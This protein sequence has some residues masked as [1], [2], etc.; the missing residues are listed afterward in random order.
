MSRLAT[1]V[2]LF[3]ALLL[4]LAQVAQMPPWEGF[5]EPGHYSYIEQIAE[6]GTWPR[7]GDP[8]SADVD[9]YLKVAPTASSLRAPWSYRDFAEASHETI[10][11]GRDA[12]HSA[13]DPGRSWR[14]G[15]IANWET[16][17]PPLYYLAMA[18]A[19]LVSKGWSLAAQLLLLRGLS[20]L[21]AWLGLCMA[22]LS[23]RKEDHAP[24]SALLAPALWPALFPMWF[25]EMSRLGNDSLV[26]FVA[27]CAW[28]ALVR[29]VQSDGGDRDHLTLG[30]ALGLGLLTKAIFLPFVL[31]VFALLLFRIWQARGD[32]GG[33]RGRVRGF[34]LCFAAVTMLA[35]WWYLLKLFETGSVIG[36]NDAIHL[37]EAGGLIDGLRQNAS[38]RW[39]ARL[40][41]HF[42]SSFLWAGT[43]SFVRPPFV[44]LIPL[45]LI[46]PLLALGYLLSLTAR[47]FES[48]LDWVPPSTAVL[49]LAGLGYHSLVLIALG[50]VGAPAWYLHAFAPVLAPLLG[51]GLAGIFAARGWRPIVSVLMFY[52]TMFLL[53][54]FAVQGLFFAGCG[55]PK[56]PDSSFYD[57]ASGSSCAAHLAVI[58]DK[59]SNISFPQVAI[60]CFAAGWVL[61]MF[62][63]GAALCCLRAEAAG[64]RGGLH[65]PTASTTPSDAAA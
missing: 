62:G 22:A 61:M 25:P 39:I 35:G 11:T 38:L 31:V 8:M 2:L 24:A 64:D 59:L 32:A 51:R 19:Y 26:V 20:Y 53:F 49:F 29:L 48:V 47:R 37:R 33:A 50:A 60:V 45:V 52:P 46:P 17:Q 27:A 7:F 5:D 12:V 1:I 41:W 23:I 55:G 36:S 40:P 6:T 63:I 34:F 65:A 13:R 18:P 58:Y 21:I 16:Q 14:T 9:E 56:G 28:L 15:R 10:Q 30:V 4:G 57:L 44:T 43:W 42:E 3:G 54:A